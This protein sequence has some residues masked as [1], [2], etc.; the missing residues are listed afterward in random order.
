MPTPRGKGGKQMKAGRGRSNAPAVRTVYVSV[1]QEPGNAGY[2]NIQVRPWDATV[3][4]GGLFRWETE[5]GRSAARPNPIV[6]M[7]IRPMTLTSNPL[8]PGFSFPRGSRPAGAAANQV[9]ASDFIS[10]H[11]PVFTL[12][13]GTPKVEIK[14]YIDLVFL[15][16]KGARRALSI[17]PDMIVET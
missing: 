7:A 4:S 6:E 1:S 15:D 17:D 9:G 11:T 14:Y 16:D 13:A 3:R 12:P 8:D 2:L 5:R 10:I